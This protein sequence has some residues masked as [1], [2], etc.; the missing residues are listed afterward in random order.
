LQAPVLVRRGDPV[1]MQLHSANFVIRA[2][3]RALSNGA[4][5]ERVA[6]ENLTSKRVV[7][8]IVTDDGR[9]TVEF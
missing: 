1:M 2:S 3:G 8:G 5:G 7:H 4:A 9:V 6:V